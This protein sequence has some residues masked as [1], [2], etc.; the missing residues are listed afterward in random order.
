M[1]STLFK[2]G[3]PRV[4]S[5]NRKLDWTIVLLRPIPASDNLHREISLLNR[6]NSGKSGGAK[7]RD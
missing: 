2:A 7:Q 6:A 3:V 1:Q 5:T 4:G